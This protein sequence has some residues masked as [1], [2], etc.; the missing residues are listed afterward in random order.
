MRAKN[1]APK[2]WL[3]L[4]CWLTV[5]LASGCVQEERPAASSP[6]V[7]TFEVSDPAAFAG[8][9]ITL[10]WKAEAVDS[11][12]LEVWGF[13]SY[14]RPQV[15]QIVSHT[16]LASVGNQTIT[17]PGAPAGVYLI[18]DS[19][20]GHDQPPNAT[21]QLHPTFYQP[22]MRRFAVSKTELYPGDDLTVG[23]ESDS[24]YPLLLKTYF[25]FETAERSWSAPAQQF[26]VLPASGEVIVT[27]PD[28][29][30][31]LV[32]IS[33]ELYY[34]NHTYTDYIRTVMVKISPT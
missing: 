19:S 25:L 22:D 14:E 31:N 2:K 33:L 30:P 29:E 15:Q 5:W 21:I 4:S 7:S 8:N 32:G 28:S 20:I 9:E 1:T 11:V 3:L 24:I 18:V 13:V 26:D 27:V 34:R 16:Q 6:Y 17:M 12:A 10:H 23:W